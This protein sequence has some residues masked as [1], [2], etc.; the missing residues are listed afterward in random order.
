MLERSFGVC[1]KFVE[2]SARVSVSKD[3]TI[4]L[5]RHELL[6]QG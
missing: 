3:G 6:D 2:V 4:N 5:L 1:N